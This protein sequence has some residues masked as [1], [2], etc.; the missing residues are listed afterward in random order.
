M[1]YACVMPRA[2]RTSLLIL[3][4]L[5]ESL[6][7]ALAMSPVAMASADDVR[8]PTAMPCHDDGSAQPE[9]PCCDDGSDCRCSMNCFGASSALAPARAE[10][11]LP[12]RPAGDDSLQPPAL[13]PAHPQRLLRPPVSS[14]G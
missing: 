4:L 6:G 12:V 7:S 10:L 8:T 11:S 2:F 13:L 14:A 1:V 5:L 9:M 3:V